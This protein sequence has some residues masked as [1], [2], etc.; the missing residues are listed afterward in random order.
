MSEKGGRLERTA[1]IPLDTV[2]SR[3]QI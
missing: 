2:G 1:A 3:M